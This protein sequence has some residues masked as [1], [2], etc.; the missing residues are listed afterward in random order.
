MA[1][2]QNLYFVFQYSEKWARDNKYDIVH[3]RE[4]RN[5]SKEGP[6]CLQP[7]CA[8]VCSEYPHELRTLAREV[9][10]L[11][12]QRSQHYTSKGALS[13]G[14]GQAARFHRI[15]ICISQSQTEHKH[16]NGN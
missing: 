16:L 5:I 15:H 3:M 4:C 14:H 6:I 7:Q 13:V 1:R 11:Q 8:H 9:A 10:Y 12:G 2:S